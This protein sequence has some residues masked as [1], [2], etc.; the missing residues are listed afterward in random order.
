MTREHRNRLNDWTCGS[1]LAVV[2]LAPIP[3]GSNRPLPWMVWTFILALL[4]IGYLGTNR[5]KKPKAAM[6][7]SGLRFLY[8][9]G[10][11]FIIFTTLQTLPL[12]PHS[13]PLP[14]DIQDNLPSKYASLS[15]SATRLATLRVCSY[16]LLFWLIYETASQSKNRK[17]MAWGL[18]AGI[19]LH[20]TWAMVALKLLNDTSLWGEKTAYLGSAT[21]TFVNRNSLATFLGMG[22]VLGFSLTL[23]RGLHP[24][25]RSDLN[26]DTALAWMGLA[27]IAIAIIS[28]QSRMGVA[29]SAIGVLVVV[30][31][32]KNS[33]SLTL[34]AASTLLIAM[35]FASGLAQ[36]SLTI[37]EDANGRIE[38]WAQAFELVKLRPFT[39]Y[40]LDAFAPAF[41][42]IH[43]PPLAS[44]VIWEYAH[45]S[46]LTLWVEC[47]VILGSIPPLIL[48]SIGIRLIRSPLVRAPLPV[49]A[50]AGLALNATHSLVD[51]SLEIQANV[52]FMLAILALGLAAK[53]PRANRKTP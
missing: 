10:G 5:V 34:G 42:L 36:R 30:I 46:Y 50:L 15:P 27:I 9:L 3:L 22:L 53:D 26:A 51:F 49:A 28:T 32:Q 47:G 17:K 52:F 33:V 16:G 7:S 40:G 2:L 44:D 23:D 41:S 29:A 43:S 8:V 19:V 13:L 20:A 39:G 12:L 4:T 18:F 31:S 11:V 6:R 38:L 24:H 21:G 45:N 1:T 35:V 14:L 48:I 37:R 25:H